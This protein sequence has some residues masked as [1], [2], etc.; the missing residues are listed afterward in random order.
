LPASAT[1]AFR[2]QFRSRRGDVHHDDRQIV[3]ARRWSEE[4]EEQRQRE[5]PSQPAASP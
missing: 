4:E 1:A 2:I 5:R 3:C